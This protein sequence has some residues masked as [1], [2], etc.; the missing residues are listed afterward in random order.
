MILLRLRLHALPGVNQFLVIVEEASGFGNPSCQSPLPFDGQRRATILKA[1]HL[2]QFRASQ[3]Q[4]EGEQEWMVQA[5]LLLPSKDAFAPDI[6][7]H[8]GQ[9]LHRS[10]FPQGSEV[11]RV[12]ESALHEAQTRQTFLHIQLVLGA[13][14]AGALTEYPWEMLHDDLGFLAFRQVCFSRSIA[15]ERMFAAPPRINRANI[16]LI[17][18]GAFD[19]ETLLVR[20]GDQ[21]QQA[22]YWGLDKAQQEGRIHLVKLPDAT[23]AALRA[24]LTESRG[25]KTPHVIHFDGHGVFGRRCNNCLAI[26]VG[27]NED[28]CQKCNSPLG[29]RQGYLVFETATGGAHYVSTKE[30]SVLIGDASRSEGESKDKEGVVSVILS[31]CQSAVALGGDSV[32]NGV[33]QNL[34]GHGI[35]TTVAMQFPV[36]AD[37][38][39]AFT[40]QFY[41]SL[42]QQ[43]SL[44]VAVQRARAA[45]GV[46]GAQWYRPV[47]YLRWQDN[48]GGQLFAQERKLT[49]EHTGAQHD[50]LV[51]L[52]RVKRAWIED[53]LEGSIRATVLIEPRKQL[54]PEAV[55]GL[56]SSQE[57]RT[58]SPDRAL[59]DHFDELGR[60]LLILGPRGAG[61]STTLLKLARSAIALAEEDPNQPLPVVLQLSS[62][63]G[64]RPIATWIVEELQSKYH[65]P[66]KFGRAWL[67]NNDL[68][69]LLDGLDEIQPPLQAAGVEAINRFRQ[70]Y[71]L[72]D[73]VVCSELAQYEALPVKLKL[74][75][76]L[77]LQPLTSDQVERYVAA[78]GEQLAALKEALSH[79]DT[80]R[81]LAQ[82][83]LMLSIMSLAFQDLPSESI[84]HGQSDT[85]NDYHSMLFSAYVD[86]MFE[87]AGKVERQPYRREETTAGLT[88][89]ARKM[90]DHDPGLFLMEQLQPSWLSTRWQR[91][92][93]VLV[94]RLLASV[95][96]GLPIWLLLAFIGETP[97]SGLL[98]GLLS[99]LA[100]GLID[101]LRFELASGRASARE[102]MT[103]PLWRSAAM[104]ASIGALFGL[105]GW[106]S[107]RLFPVDVLL[108]VPF[109]LILGFKSSRQSVTNDI[110]TVETLGLSWKGAAKGAIGGL[111]LGLVFWLVFGL[112]SAH[113]TAPIFWLPIPL[114]GVMF[115]ALQ[116]T[117][118]E[119]KNVPNQ[120]IRLSARNALL[121]GA[122]YGLGGG[123]IFGP[124]WANDGV[125]TA[126]TFGV[127]FGLQIGLLAVLSFGGLDVFNHY[128]LRA[129]LCL[130]ENL[131]WRYNHFLDYARSLIFLD[132]VGGGY[133]FIDARLMHYFATSGS[134]Q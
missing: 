5:G 83:P 117:I 92:G 106:S 37:A 28:R 114:L 128:V 87:R 32:F 11:R 47:L 110:R 129:A 50:R 51:L 9:E 94:S 55:D 85:L 15:W 108:C 7:V 46:E 126:V 60:S 30:I 81:T 109:G 59:I 53:V 4:N 80:L 127:I 45:M 35:A 56:S 75:A 65:I 105:I 10:M 133:R 21:E 27:G 63:K 20:L 88:W 131:P 6:H 107:F 84:Q 33:A 34:I 96:G 102:P 24:Y 103:P 64:R 18:S 17:S 31:A 74:G 1:L 69:L 100:L 52:S 123:F 73:I 12:F 90:L 2:V 41:R 122:I 3:F 82:T 124:F 62:W 104:A 49:G 29:D 113:P 14:D 121:A 95:V 89:L 23:L 93:Y 97:L 130:T 111:L 112:P 43:E 116:S 78:G 79:D 66:P 39:T 125:M 40:E 91:W 61:K 44:A 86:S 76:A 8:I 118:L 70:E 36:L 120:G 72:T 67:E 101:G 71:G 25:A 19:P 132:R 119:T 48:A 57:G 54:C 58:L 68:L 115:G 13:H 98:A 22:V 16:L 26:H 42:G 134:Q 99:G 77:C 38:A